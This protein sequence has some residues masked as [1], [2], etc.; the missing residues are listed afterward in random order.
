MIK[1]RQTIINIKNRQKTSLQTKYRPYLKQLIF[2]A[3]KVGKLALL[4]C[5]AS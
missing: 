5:I 4:S 3:F 2:H 1:N